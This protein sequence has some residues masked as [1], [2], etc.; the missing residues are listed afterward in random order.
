MLWPKERH[1]DVELLD[2]VAAPAMET[3]V[4]AIDVDRVMNQLPPSDRELLHLFVFER[5]KTAEIAAMLGISSA[6]VR[7]RLMRARERVRL[8]WDEAQ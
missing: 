3:P 2:E 7:V 6:A 8:R 4:E 5:F 1:R